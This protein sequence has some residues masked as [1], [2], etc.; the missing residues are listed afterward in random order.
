MGNVLI[1]TAPPAVLLAATYAVVIA[2]LNGDQLGNKEQTWTEAL[3]KV[4]I[5][6]L[7]VPFAGSFVVAIV[8][9]LVSSGEVSNLEE[10][11]WFLEFWMMMV[12]VSVAVL[13]SLCVVSL[14]IGFTFGRVSFNRA[15]QKG[16]S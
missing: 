10:A 5:P 16:M 11:R 13:V 9:V 3:L 1:Y 14:L 2:Y 7:A 12:G 15:V 6:A 4:S 8:A